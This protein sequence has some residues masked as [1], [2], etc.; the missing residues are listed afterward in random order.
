MIGRSAK[1]RVKMLGK[2]VIKVAAVEGP[3]VNGR[4]MPR[5]EVQ[6]IR[7][8][9]DRACRPRGPYYLSREPREPKRSP[10]GHLIDQLSNPLSGTLQDRARQAA[11]AARRGAFRLGSGVEAAASRLQDREHPLQPR[12]AL[13]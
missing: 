11:A 3:R 1:G 13:E 2:C 6:L 8:H 10:D 12:S 5:S 4:Q 7:N 9:R